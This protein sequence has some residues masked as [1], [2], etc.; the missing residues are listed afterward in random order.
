MQ[1]SKQ[2][3]AT[4][5][6]ARLRLRGGTGR[7][8]GGR[9]RCTAFT[10]NTAREGMRSPAPR[11]W[12]NVAGRVGRQTCARASTLAADS[13]HALQVQA[14]SQDTI[15]LTRRDRQK[16][17]SVRCEKGAR[18]SP[19]VRGIL[20]LHLLQWIQQNSSSFPITTWP[21]ACH[22]SCCTRA[23]DPT[24]LRQRASSSVR[25]PLPG[26]CSPGARHSGRR[27]PA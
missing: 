20:F 16:A 3:N 2:S 19:R 10:A 11:A 8:S 1:A 17:V 21:S 18:K 6:N 9:W 7:L 22:V 27:C 26:R 13:I 23:P 24:Q 15:F 5:S 12:H 14:G 25:S 4:Q